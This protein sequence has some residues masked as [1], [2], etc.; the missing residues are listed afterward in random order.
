MGGV[1]PS[2]TIRELIRCG[3]ISGIGEGY[4]N[5]GSLDMPAA[6]EIYRLTN[7]FM[8]RK[9]ETIRELLKLAGATP[10]NF[11]TP[12]ERGVSYLV[13][14]EGKIE[15]FEHV[16]A[17]GNPKSSSG[18]LNLFVRAMADYVSWYDMLSKG[19]CGEAWML[20]QPRSF[21][22]L[23]SPGTALMQF[24]F[25]D[26]KAFLDQTGLSIV[27]CESG[28]FFDRMGEKLDLNA[29][30]SHADALFMTIRADEGVVGW[31]CL[32]TNNV[33]DL[34]KKCQYRPEEFSFQPLFAHDNKIILRPGIFYV[35]TT[36]EAVRVSPEL[37]AELRPIDVRL[38]EFRSH[39][40]GFIDA[41]WGCGKDMDGKGQPITLEV[42]TTEGE[43]LL[44]HLQPVARIRFE[45][46]SKRPE[47]AYDSANSNYIGQADAKLSKHF[48]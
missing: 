42:T 26:E 29:E 40:A 6:D 33:L 25:F 11:S 27:H 31:E 1:L 4:I 9:G 17:Y 3:S 38:G 32:G 48:C 2:Q 22:V 37:S 46:M 12:L 5:P 10:H 41:G 36:E 16:Y 15:L 34:S 20:V 24:R 35:L 30:R 39:F 8:P 44:R 13:R 28:V 7:T 43:L 18:R 19:W 45:R 23:L 21:P 47:V 14:L